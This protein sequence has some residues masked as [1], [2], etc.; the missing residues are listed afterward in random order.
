MARSL[1]VL[2]LLI[3]GV[4]CAQDTLTHFRPFGTNPGNLKMYAHIPQGMDT[5]IA[6]PLVVVL[7]G[8]TQTANVCAK[9][10]GWNKLA[11]RHKFYVVYPEQ[12][13]INNGENCFNWFK[14]EDQ[15]RDSG[16][17]G[18]IKQMIDYMKSHYKIDGKNVFVIGL[19]A[20]AAMSSIMMAVYPEV[21]N[22]G[23]IMGGGPYKGAT[24][25]MNS[26]QAMMGAVA[27]SP[28]AWGNLVTEQN[29]GY[30]GKYPGMIIFHGNHDPIV[31]INNAKQTIKQWANINSVDE[32]PDSIVN[33]FDGNPEVDLTMY[34]DSKQQPIIYYYKV[35]NLG[36]AVPLDLGDCPRQG[37]RTDLFAV[38]KD[39]FS[40]YWAADFF[41]LIKPPYPVSGSA[42]VAPLSESSYSVPLHPASKYEWKIPP[43][44]K[45][46]SGQ[47]TNSITVK[48]DKAGGVIE[49]V[50]T[51]AN[52]CKND[53]ARLVVK[54][55]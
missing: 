22:K 27:K 24:S 8:C 7:H 52:G 28:Q 44:A 41:G 29:P 26:S 20:G 33:D 30:K 50:E 42:I 9:Q 17:P 40:T 18:S 23:G 51:D 55:E 43:G 14:G 47:G 25:V 46:N 19:S 15:V 37:G 53:A 12:I 2:F 32:M 5:T 31:N 11:D 38:D 3:I 16:E 39:F 36:H 35:K 54:V 48:F 45:I 21:F 13:I 49:V 4:S 1:I 10:T 34:Y 6:A